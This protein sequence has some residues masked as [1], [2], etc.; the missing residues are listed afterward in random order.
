M[1]MRVIVASIGLAAGLVASGA[2][3]QATPEGAAEL[4]AALE[5]PTARDATLTMMG[6]SGVE[7]IGE[8]AVE[9]DGSGYLVRSPEIRAT[10]RGDGAVWSR[11]IVVACPGSPFR[12][13]PAPAGYRLTFGGTLDCTIEQSDGPRLALSGAQTGTALLDVERALLVEAEGAVQGLD[14]RPADGGGPSIVSAEQYAYEASLAP[15]AAGVGLE[16]RWTLDGATYADPDTPIE[17]SLRHVTYFL[18][19]ERVDLGRLEAASASFMTIAGDMNQAQDPTAPPDPAT[20]GSF[21]SAY[22]DLAESLGPSGDYAIGLEGLSIARGDWSL[23]LGSLDHRFVYRGG[24]GADGGFE[25]SFSVAA[26]AAAMPAEYAQWIPTD[27]RVAVSATRLPFGDFGQALRKLGALVAASPGSP[28]E[29]MAAG[30]GSLAQP[31]LDAR[32]RLSFDTFRITAPAAEIDLGG[33]LEADAAAALG[34]VGETELRLIGF[35]DLIAALNAMPDAQEAAAGLMML[36]LMGRQAQLED[37]RTSRDYT[38]VIDPSGKL[39]LNGSDL[40]PLLA[41]EQQN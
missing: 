36:Q 19:M 7:L 2:F 37:G 1:D 33:A 41:G 15:G 4:K 25:I 22:A 35:D 13:E 11:E 16:L 12:A 32:S 20:L 39:L 26:L 17:A 21:L 34:V 27:G 24:D 23:E 6:A 3:A 40:A 8:F 10:F 5:A 14:L 30:V 18:A 31:L 29:A 28:E 9:P 38:L